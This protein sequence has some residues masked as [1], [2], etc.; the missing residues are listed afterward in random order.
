MGERL[1]DTIENFK[2]EVLNIKWTEVD[3]LPLAQKKKILKAIEG[4]KKEV[5]RREKKTAEPHETS[6]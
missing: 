3:D 5:I 1:I 4:R 2:K 6:D